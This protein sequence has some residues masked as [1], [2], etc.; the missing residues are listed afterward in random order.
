MRDRHM[1]ADAV[2]DLLYEQT[3]LL[4]VSEI[5]GDMQVLL[6][7]RDPP[8]QE[9]PSNSSS[10]GSG[11][12][13]GSL[14]AALCG[15]DTLVF[16][17]GIGENAPK[18]RQLIGEK[19][20]WLGVAIDPARNERGEMSIGSDGSRVDVFVIPAEEERAVAEGALACCDPMP[21]ARRQDP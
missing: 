15:L 8:A 12:E 10:I 11:R 17:A 16:T 21:A 9:K 5:S 19:T 1:S 2:S 14:A 7:S 6:R 20:S 13:I 18:I 3:G 4:G